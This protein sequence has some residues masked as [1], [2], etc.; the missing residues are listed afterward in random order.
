MTKWNL[1]SEKPIQCYF[2]APC[3]VQDDVGQ[4]H[5]LIPRVAYL[6][7]DENLSCYIGLYTR[8]AFYHLSYVVAWQYAELPAYPEPYVPTRA[9]PKMKAEWVDGAVRVPSD[10]KTDS[11]YLIREKGHHFHQAVEWAPWAQEFAWLD[12][13]TTEYRIYK[14]QTVEWLEITEEQS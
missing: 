6:E 3:W 2:I 13:R 14:P 9:L 8:P 11:G 12:P 5:Y 1:Q 10:A 7:K 4:I